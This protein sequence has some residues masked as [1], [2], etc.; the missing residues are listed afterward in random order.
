MLGALVAAVAAIFSVYRL[1]GLKLK[2]RSLQYSAASTQVLVDS[3]TSLLAN[4]SGS[5]EQLAARAGVFANFM[6]SPAVLDLIGRQVGLSG[7]QI[8]AA[9]PVN[10]NEPRVEQEPTAL[11]R[12]VQITGETKPYRLSFE[13][14]ATLPTIGIDSQAPTTRQA[15]ALANAA[16]VGMQRY[17]AQFEI[18]NN[19][20]PSSRVV[21]RQLGPA[22]G[23][24]VDGAIS[25]SL[26]GMTFVVTFLLWCVLMLAV[27]RALAIWRAS[28]VLQGAKEGGRQDPVPGDGGADASEAESTGPRIVDD[29]DR[30]MLII[31]SQRDDAPPAEPVR[32]TS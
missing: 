1:E 4:V 31:P 21:I 7:E 10:A 2:S 5:S 22:N 11:K 24:V 8:Y 20:P 3:Q 17:I 13:S 23:A 30:P 18:A 12:N 27:P 25:K 26:A 16:A 19:V 29:S 32:S 14:Q 9:G 15:V 6:T 28:A